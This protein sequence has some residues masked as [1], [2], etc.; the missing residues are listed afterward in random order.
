MAALNA[1]V[2]R[3]ERRGGAGAPCPECGGAGQP[4][5]QVVFEP[6]PPPTPPGC[7]VCGMVGS[8]HQ[9]V[10]ARDD[11]DDDQMSRACG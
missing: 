10:F 2:Q 6:E 5:F 7:R 9:T 3:L 4:C 8:V 11:H 1:R